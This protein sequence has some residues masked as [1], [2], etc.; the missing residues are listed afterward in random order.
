MSQKTELPLPR[1]SH[2]RDG[3]HRQRRVTTAREI[4]QMDDI[5]AL[6][7]EVR[8]LRTELAKA[9]RPTTQ[10]PRQTS[11]PATAERYGAFLDQIGG[12]FTRLINKG[13]EYFD[14]CPTCGNVK[15]PC[16][17]PLIELE[18]LEYNNGEMDTLIFSPSLGGGAYRP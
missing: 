12:Q 17:D 3:Q 7:S 4:R 11:S 5:A 6:K 16:I 15:L 18:R 2:N 13:R 1:R 8:A 9:R 14:S 10:K